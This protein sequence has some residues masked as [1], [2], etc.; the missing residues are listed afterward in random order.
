MKKLIAGALALAAALV[1]MLPGV[2][3]AKLAVNHNQTALRG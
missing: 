1:V 2:S 3:A